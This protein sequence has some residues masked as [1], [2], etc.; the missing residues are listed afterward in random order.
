MSPTGRM[1]VL[2]SGFG[3]S[4]VRHVEYP[5]LGCDAAHRS[6]DDIRP[7][8]PLGGDRNLSDVRAAPRQNF[9]RLQGPWPAPIS[10]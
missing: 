3:G 7:I 5:I 4:G 10:T 8:R 2:R 1:R 9:R 6:R